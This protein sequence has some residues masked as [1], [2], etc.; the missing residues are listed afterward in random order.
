VSALPLGPDEG[1]FETMRAEDGRVPLLARHLA[2][3]RR[4]AEALGLDRIPGDATLADEVARALAEAGPGPLRVRLTA[5]AG[6]A[7]RA[8]P[9]PLDPDPPPTAVTLRG[10]WDPGAAIREHKTTRYEHF[11]A[12]A[13]LARERGAGHAILLDRDGRPGEAATASVVVITGGRAC[14]PPVRGILAGVARGILLEKGLV[15]EAVVDAGAL[16]DAEEVVAVNALRGAMPITS[17]DGSPVGTGRRGPAAAALAAALAD[18]G[19]AAGGGAPP[20]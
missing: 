11:R 7:V 17:V 18:P 15:E 19:T 6:G 5:T 20:A 4:S 8:E 3:I 12:A 2:R 14:T 13:A 16:R 1:L 9:G 10:W